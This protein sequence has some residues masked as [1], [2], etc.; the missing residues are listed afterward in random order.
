[1]ERGLVAPD[2]CPTVPRSRAR[3]SGT[4]VIHAYPSGVVVG[5]DGQ[6]FDTGK[7]GELRNSA[8]RQ[9]RPHRPEAHGHAGQCGL[10][11]LGDMEADAHVLVRGELHAGAGGPAQ[12]LLGVSKTW[13]FRL[14]PAI[15]LQ[16]G[17]VHAAE[18][19]R[20]DVDHPSQH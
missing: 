20:A 12:H 16:G 6:S 13:D 18:L 7:H 2:C 3:D 8:C 9:S 1:M 15:R 14:A 10:D 5:E 11:P 17:P 19:I 4:A